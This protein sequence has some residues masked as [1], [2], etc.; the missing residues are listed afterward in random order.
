MIVSVEMLK[1][2]MSGIQLKAFQEQAAEY[3]LAG[4][5]SQ[6]ERYINRWLEPREVTEAVHVHQ[7]GYLLTTKSPI[8]SLPTDSNYSLYGGRIWYYGVGSVFAGPPISP[9]FTASTWGGFD[10]QVFEVTYTAG[11][12]ARPESD[13]VGE[14]ADVRLDILRVASREMTNRHDDTM[15]VKSLSMANQGEPTG[16]QNGVQGWTMDELRMH[17]RLRKRVIV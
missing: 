2:Y 11:Y 9:I 17:D 14:F 1:D 5:Q 6:L 13:T 16:P 12:D 4:V 10:S 7:D 3:V 15:S 8:V